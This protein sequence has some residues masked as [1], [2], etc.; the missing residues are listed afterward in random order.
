MPRR[1]QPD[2]D[3]RIARLRSRIVRNPSNPALHQELGKAHLKSGAFDEAESAYRRSLELA[4]EDPWTHLYLG[5]LHYAR[6]RFADALAEFDRSR[7]LAPNLAIPYVCMVDAYDNLGDSKRAG[8]FYR[9]AVAIDPEDDTARKNLRRWL[10]AC[11][12]GGASDA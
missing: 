3:E 1:S 9:R 11:E 6:R 2:L 12:D 5:N 10:H 8:E 4:P 7:V